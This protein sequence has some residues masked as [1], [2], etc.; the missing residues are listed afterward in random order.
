MNKPEFPS[1]YFIDEVREGFYVPEMMKRFWAA[2][3]MVLY[4]V[5]KIC[6]RHGIPWYADMGTLLGAVR[7]KGYVPWDDD[8]DI[9]MNREDWERFFDHAVD[10]LPEGFCVLT[11]KTNKEYGLSVG[12][13]TNSNCINI[14]RDHMD[15]FCGCPYCVGVDVYPID[16]MYKD[17]QKEKDRV[18]RG[19]A[20]N[21]AYDLITTKGIEADET[22]KL[23]AEI[24]RDNH[25]ILH[26]KGN[27]V[28]E[29]V[30]LFD[31]I[32]AE[33]KDKEYDQ[34]ALMYTWI[35]GDWANC[36]RY[37]YE[38]RI[39]IPFE[40]TTLMASKHYDELLTIYYHDYMTVKKGGGAHDY[41]IYN[42]QEQILKDNIGRNPYRYTFTKDDMFLRRNEK[43]FGDKCFEIIE[44]LKNSLTCIN[45]LAQQN[46]AE[47]ILRM[48][49]GCQDLAITLGTMIEGKYGEDCET[50]RD[51]EDF[52]ELL[53]RASMQW[54]RTVEE[55]LSRAIKEID[56]KLKKL[57]ENRNKEVVFIPCRAVW[58]DT[59]KPLYDAASDIES[60]TVRLMPI[61]YYD[62][63]P[64]GE[65]GECHDESD[66]FRR[67]DN[68]TDALTYEI[69]K[70][71]PEI[72]VIQIPFDEYSCSMTVPE[73]YYSRNLLKLC[74]ELWYVPCFD[75]EPPQ[76]P[77][78]K[79]ARSIS[80]LIEQP[81]VV[82][83][84]KIIL[85]NE[86]IRKYYIGRL[87]DIAGEDTGNYWKDKI[88][89]LQELFL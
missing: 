56:Y 84:D 28:R 68:Y 15:R 74:N 23:L 22:K 76:A 43:S 54:D 47:N 60:M 40:N 5:V 16:R 81:A 45:K 9:S 55:S 30:L 62:R 12:R 19:K 18:R 78:D 82:H 46:D 32:C 25:V 42:S 79:A 83:A 21:Q 69:E 27:I 26:R 53:Y 61:P 11:T 67:F 41:P 1:E 2:Q 29:L 89:I 87:T 51:L 33:C 36:P 66:Y 63:N 24:E 10:E 75:P 35:V 7:H 49:T 34:V 71:H 85:S 48:L 6:D 72:I 65:I 20:V 50:V 39:E 14:N 17:I 8:I 58:W 13:I 44:L 57:S 80:V 86:E 88:L 4:E 38:E 59:L 64:Y 77:D 3:L 37:L 73:K 52:C 31:R 70:K